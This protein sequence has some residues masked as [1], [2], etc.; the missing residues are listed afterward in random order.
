MC[1]GFREY[2]VLEARTGT[3]AQPYLSSSTAARESR[4]VNWNIVFEV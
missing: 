1:G 2:R 4:V 3:E